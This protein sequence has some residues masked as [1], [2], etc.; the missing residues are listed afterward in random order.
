M[1]F[2]YIDESGTPDVPGNTS[3]YVLAGMAIPVE[4]WKK[5]EKIVQGIKAKYDLEE[6]EIHTGW[7]LWPYL[8]QRKIHDFEK[9]N[10]AKRRYE[11]TKYR[12]NEL[13][14]LQTSNP[15]TYRKTKKN[16]R[17]TASYVH[18]TFE[19][20]KAFVLEVAT[21]IGKWKYCRVFAECI[22]KIFFDPNLGGRSIDEQA[23]EQ[24]VSR[25][26]KY[27]QIYSKTIGSKQFGLLIHDNNDTVKKKHTQMMIQFHQSG[28][29]W[30]QLKN[31]IETPLFVDSQL[32]S[33]VQLADIC[34]YSIRRYLEK[35]ETE[36]FNHIFKSADKKEN[37][38][39]GFRHFSE[40][41]CSCL[42]CTSR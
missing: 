41:N 31:I 18:L 26:E 37:R 11:V 34:A 16:Y 5:C 42:I 9:F 30:T 1:I 2:C 39:V 35:N 7:L 14:R 32:T 36:L 29:L 25:F 12:N 27:L 13:L 24:I 19:E 15:K 3:H 40:R 22:D 4:Y 38:I 23:F 6:A 10:Y 8:E 20:R 28:T 21:E 17:A 33:M